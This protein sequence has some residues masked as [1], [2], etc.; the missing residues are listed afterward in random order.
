MRP[1]IS[2]FIL[3]IF[4]SVSVA[5]GQVTT[6]DTPKVLEKLYSR[7]VS[8]YNDTD[9]I[10]INDSVRTI[11]NSYV[12]SDTVFT[13]KFKN[14][15]YLGQITSTDS[16][17]KIITWNLVLINSPGRYYCYILRRQPELKKNMIYRLEAEY[18]ES[19]VKTDTTYNED[20]WYGALYY[21]IRPVINDNLQYWM[22]LGIDYGNSFIS[23]KI[24]DVLSF[25]DAGSIIFGKK[26]FDSG[27]KLKFREVFEYAS[28]AM[29]SLRFGSDT[30][31]VFDHLVPFS[32]SLKN[33]RQYY[34]PD[35]SYDAYY[36]ENGLWKLKINVDAR[37]K[38]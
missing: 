13:H 8:N 21:D 30:S 19:Q 2:Y 3:L 35:Y 11:I 23:R 15:R 10:R 9:R 5:N 7:L 38:E 20:D 18:N 31:V 1:S 12:T 37:N 14:L 36:L 4:I 27:D 16:L 28:N 26:W 33:D 32:P 6:N 34:G 29:M 25:S 24:I 22:L 17:I